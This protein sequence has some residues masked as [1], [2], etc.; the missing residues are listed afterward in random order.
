MKPCTVFLVSS[1]VGLA[2]GQSIRARQKFLA[3]DVYLF[4]ELVC[5]MCDSK[6]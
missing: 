3:R 4:G 2:S 5:G 1:L 6:R